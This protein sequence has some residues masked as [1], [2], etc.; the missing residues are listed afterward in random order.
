MNTNTSTS[1]GPNP[2][3]NPNKH[4]TFKYIYTIKCPEKNN[5]FI[6]D[7]KYRVSVPISYNYD[8]F[9]T[10]ARAYACP[11]KRQRDKKWYVLRKLCTENPQKFMKLLPCFDTS[12]L[13]H[14]AYHW[15]SSD[16]LFGVGVKSE[17][18]ELVECM[19]SSGLFT[20][21][22]LNFQSG[23][24]FIKA[25]MTNIDIAFQMLFSDKFPPLA[26]NKFMNNYHPFELLV[27]NKNTTSKY[28]DRFENLKL[29]MGSDKFLKDCSEQ[30]KIS[31]M[32]RFMRPSSCHKIVSISL[33][34]EIMTRDIIEKMRFYGDKT[35]IEEY[36]KYADA[37]LLKML[38]DS[39]KVSKEWARS[40]CSNL[41]INNYNTN[42]QQI[43]KSHEKLTDS[44][45]KTCDGL[46]ARLVELEIKRCDLNVELCELEKTIAEIKLQQ[47]Q[48]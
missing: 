17:N 45:K 31:V 14:I 43:L 2:N 29:A 42:I 41:D 7:Y 38:L 33:N 8:V 46:E 28:P 20:D 40:V 34:C 35:I 25:C 44:N 32:C 19:L 15:E 12:I 4:D 30:L 27:M 21:E 18:S 37:N 10:I 39:E 26:I 1:T 6:P 22:T 5:I 11:E 48:H 16:T 36:C 9:N 13:N 47:L 23:D 24:L 3:P